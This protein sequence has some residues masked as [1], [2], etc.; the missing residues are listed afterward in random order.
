MEKDFESYL[1]NRGYKTITEK[2]LPSTVYQYI[3]GINK[4]CE[5][6]YTTWQ[7]LADNIDLIIPLYDIGGRKEHL[8]N[9]SNKTIINALKRYRE[10][11]RQL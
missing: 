3:K 1:I 6:E 2:G 4:V 5:W 8:G 10:F 11:I 9:Q 7:S